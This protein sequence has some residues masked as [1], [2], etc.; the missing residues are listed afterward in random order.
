MHYGIFIIKRIIG[1]AMR[2]ILTGGGTCGH[3]MPNIA[4]LPYLEKHFD[5][6]AYFGSENSM[7]QKICMEHDI[8]FYYTETVK[9]ERQK[10]WR[11]L[12]IPYVLGSAIN[13]AKHLLKILKPNIVF[14]KGGYVSLPTC[15][16]CQSLNIPYVIHESDASLGVANKLVAN[17]AAKVILSSP[18]P[19]KKSDNF[20]VIGNPIRDEIINGNASGLPFKLQPNKKNILIIGGSLGAIAINQTVESALPQL[21]QQ[22]N[23]IHILGKNNRAKSQCAGYYPINFADNIGD[24][25]AAADIIIS[26]AGANAITEISAVGK[27]AVYIPLP[28]GNSRGDQEDNAK[29]QLKDGRAVVLNQENLSADKLIGAIK[30]AELLPNPKPNYDREICNKIVGCILNAAQN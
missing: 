24:Y 2:I 15:F 26:R 10:I 6:I 5:S 23:V 14:A 29:T 18:I 21:T 30:D 25:Y 9:L 12:K 7:E 17:K 27:R 13:S 28:K 22:Y 8:P 16:A 1:G 11:N 20:T 19:N 4:L 3:I